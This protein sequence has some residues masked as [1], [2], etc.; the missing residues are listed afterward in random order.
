MPAHAGG[1]GV[2]DVVQR[3]R[4][5]RVLSDRIVIVIRQPSLGIDDHIFDDRSKLDSVPDEWLAFLRHLDALRVTAAFEIEN[6]FVTPTVLVIANEPAPRVGGQCRL[7][8]A[9][10]SA[11][12]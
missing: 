9:A 7:A 2:G 6:T 1:N 3:I 5:T 4:A 12:N 8:S 10:Q 11:E